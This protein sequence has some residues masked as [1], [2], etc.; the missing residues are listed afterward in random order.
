MNGWERLLDKMQI[1]HC[2]V[3]TDGEPCGRETYFQS[4][5]T[6]HQAEQRY[7]WVCKECADEMAPFVFKDPV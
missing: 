5:Y 4:V 1:H 2:E 6:W 3:E 7:C